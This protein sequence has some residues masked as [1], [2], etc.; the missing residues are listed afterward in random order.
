M[1]KAALSLNDLLIKKGDRT[2]NEVDLHIKG[3]AIDV[4]TIYT[5]KNLGSNPVYVQVTADE[6]SEPKTLHA[7]GVAVKLTD[8]NAAYII[9]VSASEKLRLSTT[10]PTDEDRVFQ[11]RV[12]Q[13]V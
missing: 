3:G 13:E 5:P 2:S 9:P 7:K 10:A 6:K 1:S 4:I 8:S 12:L 11:V